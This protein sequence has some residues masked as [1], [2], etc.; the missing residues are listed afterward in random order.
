MPDSPNQD[1]NPYASPQTMSPAPARPLK[2]PSEHESAPCPRCRSKNAETVP[3]DPLRGRAGPTARDHV[4]CHDCGTQFNGETG[5][6][7]ST[8]FN[9]FL[10][11]F[12][13]L[14]AA[15]WVAL[16]IFLSL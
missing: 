9:V 1:E 11:I 12:A 7:V 8:H 15:A 6:L 14:A 5:A 2:A 3:Y 4:R 10:L 16:N 13:I